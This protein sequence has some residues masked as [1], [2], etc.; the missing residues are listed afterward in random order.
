MRGLGDAILCAESFIDNEPFAVL[1]GDDIIYHEQEP[2]M[3]QL[4]RM[5]NKYGH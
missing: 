1:L 2:A 4:M 5:Y 3:H